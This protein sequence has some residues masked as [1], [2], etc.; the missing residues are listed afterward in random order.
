LKVDDFI[1]RA[2]ELIK[3]ADDVLKTTVTSSEGIYRWVDQGQFSGFRAASLSFIQN[4]YGSTS[5]VR[6]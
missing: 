6:A 4:L 5:I 3:Q 2:E 1:K